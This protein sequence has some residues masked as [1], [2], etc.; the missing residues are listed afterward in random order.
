[1]WHEIKR[2]RKV[3]NGSGKQN[4]WRHLKSYLVNFLNLQIKNSNKKHGITTPCHTV[5]SQTAE[6]QRQKECLKGR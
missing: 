1:M 3:E 6:N 5:L 2:T 4:R